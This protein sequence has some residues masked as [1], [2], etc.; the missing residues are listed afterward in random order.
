M[1][2]ATKNK[3]EIVDFLWDWA[4]NSD[5]AKLLVHKVVSTESSLLKSDR[6]EIFKYFLH[7]I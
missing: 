6:E 2:S 1:T 5:W 4:D 3:K 7:K